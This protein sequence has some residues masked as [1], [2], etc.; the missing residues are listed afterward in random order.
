MERKS[1][2]NNGK[3]LHIPMH[4]ALPK[5]FNYIR[6]Y[7]GDELVKEFHMGIAMPESGRNCDFYSALY[8]G[9]FKSD[10]VTLECDEDVP[11]GLFDGIIAGDEPEKEP[12]LYP[13]L[14]NEPFR[15][16]FHFSPRRGWLNDPNGLFYKDGVFNMYYQHNPLSSRHGGVNVSWG[17]ATTED[18][19]HFKEHHVA[20]T[21]RNSRCHIAS[22]SAVVDADNIA[23]KGNGA[24]LAAYTALQSLQFN[25][26]PPVTQADGQILM[27]STDNGMN[28]EYFENYPIIPVPD[29]EY[30]RDPKI[31]IVD[32]KLCLIVYE[33][34]DGKNVASFYTSDDG[35][36]WE[37]V[38]RSDN[39]YE[40]P[41]L[42]EIKVTDSDEK[43]WVLYGGNG[44]YSVGKFENFVFTA[45][46]D[47]CYLDYGET[48]YAGQ[49]FN[50][51]PSEDKRYHI[52][53]SQENGEYCS[54]I[55][56]GYSYIFGKPFAQAMSLMCELTLHKTHAG[57]RLFRKPH[58]NIKKLRN[59][60][61][62]TQ[63]LNAMHLD[64]P[65]EYEFTMPIDKDFELYVGGCGFRY[66]CK[67]RKI[68]STGEREYVLTSDEIKIRMFVD[69]R[70]VEMF[71]SDEISL[72][73]FVA[74]ENR[75]TEFKGISYIE[76]VKHTLSSIWEK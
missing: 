49:T 10:T 58:E 68:S 17:H 45:I 73:F 40:C 4:D 48:V 42:F 46:E 43:L 69:T 18:G 25:D 36:K 38:S 67:T 47:G 29:N 62:N 23:K 19:V 51:H 11:S 71:I 1:F 37:C 22:G 26:R 16:K 13:N 41:D 12:E 28:F 76:S 57:Y 66:D 60:T 27:Y 33:Q 9:G 59:Q 20:I 24:V 55:T 3:Y 53:W 15:Q 32:G 35:Q 63:I 5:E 6:I 50:N 75:T 44:R 64:S 30:W 54:G 39:L 74:E 61:E 56:V 2:K 21:P 65:A 52:A 31:L 72:T 7:D 8:I 14:Y 70:S 34:H